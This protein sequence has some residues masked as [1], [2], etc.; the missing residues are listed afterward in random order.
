MVMVMALEAMMV[1]VLFA[2]WWQCWMQLW[3][4]RCGY[5]GCSYICGVV[6]MVTMVEVPTMMVVV[7][8]VAAIAV[9]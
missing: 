8:V 1:M 9:N 3:M 2:C 4:H 6:V 7:V 5:F